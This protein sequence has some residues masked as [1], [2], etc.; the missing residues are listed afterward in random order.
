MQHQTH[1]S[2]LCTLLSS[3]FPQLEVRQS[4]SLQC[5][6]CCP[7]LAQYLA[8]SGSRG[9][10]LQR[11]LR[12]LQSQR[13]PT[14]LLFNCSQKLWVK[15]RVLSLL[16]PR[17]TIPILASRVKVLISEVYEMLLLPP[18][19]CAQEMGS[20]SSCSMRISCLGRAFSH[21][22]APRNSPF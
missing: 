22:V 18:S 11:V 1:T 19:G 10:V 5:C 20:L 2:P 15:G 14:C 3:I 7:D 12:A 4:V 8:A 9:D 13:G 17:P 6:S 21:S 16:L